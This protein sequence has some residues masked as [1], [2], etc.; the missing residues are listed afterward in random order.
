MKSI[1]ELIALAE[2]KNPEA[3][4]DLAY[5]YSKGEG[6]EKNDAEA[7]RL[8]RELANIVDPYNNEREYTDEEYEAFDEASY[9]IGG[10]QYELGYHYYNGVGVEQSYEEAVK[11]FTLGAGNNS[12][13]AMNDLAKCYYYGY[14]VKKN[15]T[16]ALKWFKEAV[17]Q[18]HPESQYYLGLFYSEG[19][20]VRADV[21]I[22][23]NWLLLAAR[24]FYFTGALN[25]KDTNMDKANEFYNQAVDAW[26]RAAKMGYAE[27][28]YQLDHIRF[29]DELTEEEL[30]AVTAE[31]VGR[32]FIIAESMPWKLDRPRFLPDSP[33]DK[34]EPIPEDI[35]VG[36]KIYHKSFGNGTV[37]KAEDNKIAVE[38]EAV[39]KKTFVNPDAFIGGFLYKPYGA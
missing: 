14:G 5:C 9:Y 17:A 36:D 34:A 25:Y 2:Q 21:K 8:W 37:T 10:A 1:N 32:Q 29:Y 7:I 28:K 35:S 30:D 22:A 3:Q 19:T 16:E 26:K 31:Y 4:F 13:H 33:N 18:W 11:W 39:G 38:F 24:G 6:V 12:V 20:A 15:Y 23:A 27:A